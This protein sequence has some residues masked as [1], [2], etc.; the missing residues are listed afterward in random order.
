MTNFNDLLVLCQ[1]R[2]RNQIIPVRNPLELAK[3]FM[4]VLVKTGLVLEV[5]VEAL[6][7]RK[8]LI[9]SWRSCIKM[10]TISETVRLSCGNQPPALS[11]GPA[12]CVRRERR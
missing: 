11:T 6:R 2:R 7:L 5:V 12:A 1:G 3:R 4:L 10:P 8:A 9:A